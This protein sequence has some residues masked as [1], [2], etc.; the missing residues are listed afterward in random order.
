MRMFTLALALVLTACA[1]P[2][3]VQPP[4]PPAIPTTQS[5]CVAAKGTWGAMGMRGLA[6]CSIPYADAGKT[7]TDGD[8]CRGD[9]RVTEPDQAMGDKPITGQCQASSSPFGCFA[10]VEDGRSTGFLCVD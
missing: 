8:Q 3:P 5:A 2:P 6:G 1:A 7:C 10:R 4:E 9:C